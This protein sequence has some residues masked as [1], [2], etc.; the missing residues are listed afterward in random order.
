[1]QS[2][3][4]SVNVFDQICDRRFNAVCLTLVLKHDYVINL[5]ITVF[6][7]IWSWRCVS[8][9]ILLRQFFLGI[10]RLPCGSCSDCSSSS[11]C[12][13]SLLSCLWCRFHIWLYHDLRGVYHDHFIFRWLLCSV[14]RSFVL[15]LEKSCAQGLRPCI[16][17][18]DHMWLS[19]DLC[20]RLLFCQSFL[21]SLPEQN[22]LLTCQRRFWIFFRQRLKLSAKQLLLLQAVLFSR[23]ACRSS[24][25]A[26]FWGSFP[27]YYIIL[28][29]NLVLSGRLRACSDDFR[30]LNR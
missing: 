27:A 16:H 13:R 26:S 19:L 30:G 2:W 12:N 7:R 21:S 14:R 17:R 4:R 9:Q 18:L 10:W 28:V 23:V 15:L 8:F 22:F 5:L 29:W 25:A 3:L 20:S 11:A 6:L 24:P 1:M